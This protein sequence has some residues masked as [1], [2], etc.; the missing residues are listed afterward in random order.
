M[1]LLEVIA[2]V[3]PSGTGKSHRAIWVAHNNNIDFIIDDGLLISKSTIAAGISAKKQPTKIGAIKTALFNNELHAQ[4]VVEEIQKSKP[5]KLLILG[6]SEGMI[7][8]II[9]RLNLPSP[10]QYINIQDIATS[11]EIAKAQYIRTQFNKHIIPVPTTE[12]EQTFHKRLIKPIKTI[13]DFSKQLPNELKVE[14]TIVRPTFNFYGRFFISD[15]TIITIVN[16]MLLNTEGICKPIKTTIENNLPGELIIH[17]K[18]S[19]IYGQPI[20]KIVSDAKKRIIKELE[21]MTGLEVKAYHILVDK[22]STLKST[23]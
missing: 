15:N 11:E 14:Q 1:I 10:S 13:F 16:H 5:K 9:E 23:S 7:N 2:L 20:L 18:V 17:S 8:R 22:L 19:I 12:V 4:E 3:G 21:Y 6:T